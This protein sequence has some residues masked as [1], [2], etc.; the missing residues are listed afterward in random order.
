MDFI[1]SMKGH[2][3]WK[4]GLNSIL[5]KDADLRNFPGNN[6]HTHIIIYIYRWQAFVKD[7]FTRS[8]QTN[9]ELAHGIKGSLT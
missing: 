7:D 6:Q 8:D 1:N 9:S 5:A 2:V 4:P 3:E